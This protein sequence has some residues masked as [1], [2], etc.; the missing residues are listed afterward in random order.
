MATGGDKAKTRMKNRPNFYP[1]SEEKEKEITSQSG[2]KNSPSVDLSSQ[3]R[4]R[5]KGQQESSAGPKRQKEEKGSQRRLSNRGQSQNL[6]RSVASSSARQRTL[7][8]KKKSNHSCCIVSP[9]GSLL[10]SRKGR[11]SPS[12]CALDQNSKKTT[13]GYMESAVIHLGTICGAMSA[14]AFR[15]NTVRGATD[16]SDHCRH[17]PTRQERVS[18]TEMPALCPD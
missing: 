18:R 7:G 5:E 3:R 2:R 15:I 1:G 8:Q 12:W 6:L 10:S 11:V 4:R 9:S 17:L 16:L 14:V 13:G